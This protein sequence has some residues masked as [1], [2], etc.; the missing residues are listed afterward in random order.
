[1]SGVNVERRGVNSTFAVNE[2]LEQLLEAELQTSLE[3]F[4]ESPVVMRM[5]QMASW[6]VGGAWSAVKRMYRLLTNKRIGHAKMFD[7][8][9]VE[10]LPQ[11]FGA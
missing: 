11:G 3:K 9:A 2:A 1:M 4:S 5:A 10:L 7:Q 6:T 8:Q